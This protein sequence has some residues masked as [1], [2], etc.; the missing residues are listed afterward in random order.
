MNYLE[1]FISNL[2]GLTQGGNDTEEQ[3]KG[4]AKIITFPKK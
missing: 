4:E 3:S 2:F 1:K